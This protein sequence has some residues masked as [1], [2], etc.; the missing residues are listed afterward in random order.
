MATLSIRVVCI[1]PFGGADAE[2]SRLFLKC[3]Y[4]DEVLLLQPSPTTRENALEQLVLEIDREADKIVEDLRIPPCPGVLAKL[5]KEVRQEEPGY[6]G[7]EADQ[8]R[9]GAGSGRAENRQRTVRRVAHPGHVGEPGTATGPVCCCDR[10]F[11]SA[12]IH[13]DILASSGIA[14]VAAQ[15]APRPITHRDEIYT[16]ALFRDCGIP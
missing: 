7:F 15:L 12:T 6:K 16:F 13:G 11:P 8:C 9:Y 3:R 10:P 2:C 14:E 1:M 5:L 4:R